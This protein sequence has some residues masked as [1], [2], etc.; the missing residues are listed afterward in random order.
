VELSR[1]NYAIA[2]VARTESL[3]RE[4]CDQIPGSL[5]LAIDVTDADRVAGAV[6]QVAEHFGRLDAIIHSA[7]VAPVATVEQ[8]TLQQWR[9]VIDTNL[10]SAFYLARAAWPIFRKQNSGVIV[11]ISSLAARDPFPGF[12]AYAAAKAGVNLLDLVLAR[13]GAEI[14]VRVHTLALGAVETEM[15]RAIMTPEQF[16]PT[17]TLAPEE[18]AQTIAACVTGE[19]RYT[20]GEVIYLHKTP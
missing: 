14:G 17:K 3:L 20:S 11:N 19:L 4:L 1:R 16:P 8:T 12:G 2:A 13:E 18:V 15:F 7:G 9:E 5:A 10:S 6:Q